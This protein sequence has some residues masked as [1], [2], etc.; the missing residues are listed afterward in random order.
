M[1]RLHVGLWMFFL[2]VGCGQLEFGVEPEATQRPLATEPLLVIRTPTLVLPT[3]PGVGVTPTLVEM[4]TEV[5]V[6]VDERQSTLV[7]PTLSPTPTPTLSPSPTQVASPVLPS[8]TSVPRLGP[9]VRQFTAVPTQVEP[10]DSL[11]LIWEAVGDTAQLCVVLPEGTLEAGNCSEW[12]LV[13]SD[14]FVINAVYRNDVTLELRVQV[15]EQEV[16]SGLPIKLYCSERW[17]FFANPPT[18]CPA[19]SSVTSKAAAQYFE[20]GWMLWVEELATIYAF[21]DDGT[22]VSFTDP[23]ATDSAETGDGGVHPPDGLYA[24]IRGFGLVWRG[25]VAEASGGWIGERLGW[26]LVPEFGFDMTYQ[27]VVSPRQLYLTHPDGDVIEV[28]PLEG[29]WS[30]YQ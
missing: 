28:K 2:L 30:F 8:P 25:E 1:K 27:L 22:Y 6:L 7:L 19:R 23:L 10:G 5:P 26:G 12:P 13:G 14:F 9:E 21:F 17:W 29:Q 15:G 3:P 4:V 18:L 16:V 24:P 20:Q 11:A